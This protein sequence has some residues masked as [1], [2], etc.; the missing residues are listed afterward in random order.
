MDKIEVWILGIVSILSMLL[1][2]FFG[3][4]S[5]TGS[6]VEEYEPFDVGAAARTSLPQA[7]VRIPPCPLAQ[8]G[9]APSELPPQEHL[10]PETIEFS[11]DRIPIQW[12]GQD[13]SISLDKERIHTYS[14]SAGYYA[15]D[16]RRYLQGF[17]CTYAYKVKN[18]PP[19]CERVALGYNDGVLSFARG[20]PTDEYIANQAAGIDFAAFFML[21]NPD[22]GI[23]ASSPIAY[24][25][26][27]S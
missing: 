3:L 12:T 26:W 27:T 24:L 5:I 19:Y 1:L 16:P 14:G 22:Y 21:V 10:T 8:P 7:P 6:V 4:R 18:P 9:Y 2:L 13:Q 23:I 20:Y 15:E 11:V 25:R 17:L